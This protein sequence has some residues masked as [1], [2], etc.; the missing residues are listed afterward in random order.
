MGSHG[1]IFKAGFELVILELEFSHRNNYMPITI[2]DRFCI[3][4]DPTHHSYRSFIPLIIVAFKIITP[5]LIYGVLEFC[6]EQIHIFS[7]LGLGNVHL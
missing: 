1:R 2:A 7:S 3:E 5:G 6:K 4:M